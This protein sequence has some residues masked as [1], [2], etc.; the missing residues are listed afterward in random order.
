MN[1]YIAVSSTGGLLG[2]RVD[3]LAGMA[4]LTASRNLEAN[5]AASQTH[6][7]TTAVVVSSHHSCVRKI[8]S[9]MCKDSGKLWCGINTVGAFPC[10]IHWI[11]RKLTHSHAAWWPRKEQI[12]PSLFRRALHEM[13]KWARVTLF[14]SHEGQL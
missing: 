6:C 8:C 10:E 9:A 7:E 5:A 2:K 12:R 1:Y 14:N 11:T 13:E 3:L 4:T